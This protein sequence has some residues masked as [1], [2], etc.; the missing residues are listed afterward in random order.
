MPG[1]NY[2]IP[3]HPCCMAQNHD[4]VPAPQYVSYH[5]LLLVGTERCLRVWVK[6]NLFNQT[7]V[8]FGHLLFKMAL[9]LP[10]AAFIIIIFNYF[11]KSYLKK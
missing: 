10:S 4:S 8:D 6:N 3:F 2:W 1:H 9:F 7:N 11:F 5:D